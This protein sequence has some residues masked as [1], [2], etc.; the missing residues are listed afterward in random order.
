MPPPEVEHSQCAEDGGDG[1]DDEEGDVFYGFQDVG[2]GGGV[3]EGGVVVEGLKR[4]KGS[5]EDYE[6]CQQDP[7]G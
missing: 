2:G 5:G 1:G 4:G 3:R 7:L 6:A